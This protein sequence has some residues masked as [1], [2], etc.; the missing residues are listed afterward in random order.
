MSSNCASLT[1]PNTYQGF[2]DLFANRRANWGGK[3]G[4]NT[5]AVHRDFLSDGTER[6]SLKYHQTH[7]VTHFSDGQV[8]FDTGGHPT[9]TTCDR[10]Q[11]S[12][13]PGWTVSRTNGELRLAL[14]GD[15]STAY[16]NRAEWIPGST[17]WMVPDP[18]A[19]GGY[20]VHGDRME[21]VVEIV[22]RR[23]FGFYGRAA[24]S[25]QILAIHK[26]GFG[27]YREALTGFEGDPKAGKGCR[28]GDP[29]AVA[30][31][32]ALERDNLRVIV[33]RSI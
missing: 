15:E 4:H 23:V 12:C 31:A 27:V 1:A 18:K 8:Y 3:V 13:P 7:V 17:W 24:K 16:R 25:H 10:M 6:Y 29:E 26:D 14:Q 22:F 9:M 5:Y 19:P 30:L 33:R 20:R 28:S 21:R 11:E 2:K 32:A